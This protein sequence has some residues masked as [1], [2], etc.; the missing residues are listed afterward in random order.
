[1]AIFEAGKNFNDRFRTFLRLFK[2]DFDMIGEF[3]RVIQ[4]DIALFIVVS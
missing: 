2:I 1:M 4:L 3:M